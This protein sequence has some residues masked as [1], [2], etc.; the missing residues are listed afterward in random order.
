MG[1]QGSQSDSPN[2][3]GYQYSPWLPQEEDTTH[4]GQMTQ[5][6]QDESA[7]KVSSLLSRFHGSRK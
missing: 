6:I 4:L 1:S 2:N 3:T 5:M 7:L